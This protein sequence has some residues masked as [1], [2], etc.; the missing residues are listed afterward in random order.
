MSDW[1][2]LAL[3]AVLVVGLAPRLL[4]LRADADTSVSLLLD[5]SF[6][7]F[8]VAQNV[9]D[10]YGST[11]DRIHPTNGYHP[12]WLGM[13]LPIAALARD[14]WVL[15][16]SAVAL[17]ILFNTLTAYL[18]WRV[19]SRS[20]RGWFIAA[21]GTALYFLNPRVTQSGVNGLE[22]ALS[23]FCVMAGV[24]LTLLRSRA[25]SEIRGHRFLL[26]LALGLMFLAR[27][28]N[29][30]YILVLMGV[31]LVEEK[32]G[33]RFGTF[34]LLGA[35]SGLL[36]APWLAWNVW[37]FGALM[38]VSGKACPYML[39][40]LFLEAG[41]SRTDLWI[42]GARLS[43]K[44][45]LKGL[46]DIP[47]GLPRWL[48]WGAGAFSVLALSVRWYDTN[49][50]GGKA[51]RRSVGVLLALGA[52]AFLLLLVHA[53]L[54]WHPRDY[55]CDT[56][57]L[58]LVLGFSFA[59]AFFD[60]GRVAESLVRCCYGT[61]PLDHGF[62]RTV[63]V[64]LSLAALV[65]GGTITWRALD[66]GRYPH[67]SELLEAAYWLRDNVPE[68][69]VAAGFNVGI[70]GFFSGR[71]VVNLDGVI[72]NAA[73]DA[74]VQRDLFGL[75]RRAGVRYYVDYD[76][77]MLDRYRSFWGEDREAVQMTPVA[78]IRRPDVPLWCGSPVRVLR[79]DWR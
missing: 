67:Q 45:F 52:G 31:A 51:L 70:V 29:A 62:L 48:V 79:L 49:L 11:F 40:T 64:G 22:V 6:Y 58:L 50:P 34:C 1:R 77:F 76:P 14:P 55:Y 42:E 5:D 9:V 71:Q 8:K 78:T 12:L 36:V 3:L 37:R 65:W 54:R 10:G 20:V 35:V 17:S 30:F 41:H 13:L 69:E 25:P 72:N 28:D 74:L 7:Y 75:M 24:A 18:I 19:L 4:F 56:A 44:F 27:T 73:Y 2:K 47:L 53:G 46:Y 61:V 32:P 59:L 33:R 16:R 63:L 43:A 38:Q 15:V 26:G 21:L 68:D 66:E 23:T 57:I 60:P 39:Q